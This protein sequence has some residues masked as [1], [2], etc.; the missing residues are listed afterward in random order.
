M[1]TTINN[2]Q[3]IKAIAAV[4]SYC[5]FELSVKRL[6][7]YKFITNKL[8][9]Q[10]IFNTLSQAIELIR[11]Y[12]RLELEEVYDIEEMLK[13]A[14]KDMVLSASELLSIAKQ[15]V[16]IDS[17]YKYCNANVKEDS[18]IYELVYTLNKINELHS[19]IVKKVDNN[20][21]VDNASEKLISIREHIRHTTNN[22]SLYIN[23]FIANN[24]DM[25]MDSISTKRNDRYCVLVKVSDKNKIK[26]IIH[27]ESSSGQAVYLEPERLIKLNNSLS[28]LRSEEEN[29]ILQILRELTSLVKEKANELS[30]NLDTL[31]VLDNIFAKAEYAYANEGCVPNIDTD[32]LLLKDARHPLINKELVVPNTFKIDKSYNG[33]VISGSNTGGKSVTIKTIGLFSF[34]AQCGFPLL[35]S[36]ASIIL[37]NK[38]LID[39]G[40]EQSIESSLSTFSAHIKKISEFLKISDNKTL[41]LIDELGSGTDPKDGE[42]LAIAIIEKL[43]SMNA[44]FVV[45][46]H[47]EKVKNYARNNDRILNASVGFDIND[48]SPTYKYY[49]N[50]VGNSYA[51]DIAQ[52]YGL[53]VDILNRAESIKKEN[54]TEIDIAYKKI[55]EQIIENQMINEQI[56]ILRNNLDDEL[57]ALKLEKEENKNKMN[58]LKQEQIDGFN[59]FMEESKDKANSIIRKLKNSD[60]VAKRHELL[61]I[62]DELNNLELEEEQKEVV[63]D[64]NK[65]DY[66]RIKSMNYYGNII[67][68]SKDNATVLSNGI[69]L[70]VKLKDLSKESKPLQ[71]KA[72]SKSYNTFK[73]IMPLECNLIGLRVEEALLILDKYIDNAL[74]A[75]LSSVRII[76]GIGTGALQ[77]AVHKYLK[78][79]KHVIEFR[80]GKEGEGGL[81]A[82]IVTLKK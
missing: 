57:T 68:I 60:S 6:Y 42:A 1:N 50:Q 66:V 19:V 55:D 58:A 31:V 47:F 33:I 72:K 11:L 38:I 70:K 69:K 77:K 54:E 36:E 43:L 2:L 27:G 74:L 20:G 78:S 52:K 56:I 73:T 7:D 40:D 65:D 25:L 34:L 24:H 80:F 64:F 3:V 10:Y 30:A 14:N 37:F 26:G 17:C 8:E 82:T 18:N 63:N 51:L 76:H 53:D 44:T 21:V 29:E 41:I 62:K 23:E 22:I 75:S 35:C 16:A 81:G 45:T 32:T 71:K 13:K 28:E 5:S 67:D 61:N 49:E 46:T 39:S 12:D 15:K 9:L 4:E 59:E 79:S 48:M